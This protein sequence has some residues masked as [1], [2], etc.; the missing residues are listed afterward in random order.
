MSVILLKRNITA[1]LFS[2]WKFYCCK[3]QL[4]RNSLDSNVHKKQLVVATSA[5]FLT[6][7]MLVTNG[8][9]LI[10]VTFAGGSAVVAMTLANDSLGA[11]SSQCEIID[12]CEIKLSSTFTLKKNTES[13][14]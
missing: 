4:L 11:T 14:N 3:Q 2:L 8:F 1:T 9:Y 12:N 6:P 7:C 5:N 13:V 10:T